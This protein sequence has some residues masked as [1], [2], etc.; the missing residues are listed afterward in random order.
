MPSLPAQMTAIAIRARDEARH[1]STLGQALRVETLL[2]DATPP[3]SVDDLH[4][5]QPTEL[6]VSFGNEANTFS[7]PDC[8]CRIVVKG[9]GRVLQTV[10]PEPYI[11][12]ATLDS[13][14]TVRFPAAAAPTASSNDRATSTEKPAE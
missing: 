6:D 9:N 5:G 11:A 4:A 10:T 3:D 8:N 1:W 2:P 12:G 13:K 14:A 7:L